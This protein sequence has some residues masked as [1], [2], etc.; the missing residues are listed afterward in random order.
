MAT[1]IV[2]LVAVAVILAGMAGLAHSSIGPQAT[3]SDSFREMRERT[4]QAARTG[5]SSLGVTVQA[6]GS[7]V[8]WSVMNDG[9]ARLHS[10][11]SWDLFMVYQDAPGGGLQIQRLAYT[12]ATSPAAGEWTVEGIYR[13]VSTLTGEVYEPGI[14]NPGEELIVRA[15]VSPAVATPTDNSILLAVTSGVTVT[16]QFSN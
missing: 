6:G 14:V 5:M 10:F 16:A 7:T 2:A 1:L 13:D 3:L 4:G 12:D 8:D 15:V 11:E 9:Q